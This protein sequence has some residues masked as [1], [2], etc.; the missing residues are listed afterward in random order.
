MTEK[1]KM[2]RG[3]F[4][5][6]RDPELIAMYHKARRL[7][8]EYNDQI[9]STDSARREQILKELLGFKGDNVWIEPPFHTDY[10]ENVSIGE[11]TFVNMNCV[12]L[13]DNK[14]VV[15]S[16]VLI[17]PCVQLYTA[18]HP[19]NAAERILADTEL[20]KSRQATYRTNSKPIEIGDNA[21]IGGNV[22][23][24][25]GVRIGENTT[26]GACSLVTKDIPDNV[27]AFGNPC[28]V[29]KEL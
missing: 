25:P 15:G 19:L 11:N 27:L 20:D 18:G 28:R 7:L 5:N 21:W 23:I 22:V 16:N 17:A 3:E 4:Y 2:L 10:G 1:E 29:V 8:K 26:I 12:F 24:M 13:D 6:A 9:D 14:I